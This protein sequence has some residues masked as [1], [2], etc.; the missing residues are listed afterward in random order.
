MPPPVLRA[1]GFWQKQRFRRQRGGDG[2]KRV[3]GMKAEE[4]EDF[5]VVPVPGQGGDGR[6]TSGLIGFGL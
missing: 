1:A 5:A 6:V 4:E 3:R 2:D